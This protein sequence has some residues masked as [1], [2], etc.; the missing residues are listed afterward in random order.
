MGQADARCHGQ[1]T[2]DMGNNTQADTGLNGLME[3]LD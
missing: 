3:I 1:W 2:V